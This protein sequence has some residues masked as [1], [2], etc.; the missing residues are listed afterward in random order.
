MYDRIFSFIPSNL[1][2]K[3]LQE[4]AFEILELVKQTY[5]EHQ[6]GKTHTPGSFFLRYPDKPN[7]RII[8]LPAFVEKHNAAGIKWIASHP[9]NHQIGLPRAS[10]IIVLNDYETGFPNVCM[11]GSQI[12]AMRTALSALLAV[13][14]LQCSISDLKQCGF[15]GTGLI[16]GTIYDNLMKLGARD[17]SVDLFDSQQE[18]C[19]QFME[20]HHI[21]THLGNIHETLSDLLSHCSTVF[22]T[23]TSLKPYVDTI[24][25]H[26]KPS[27]FLL[28]ISLRDLAPNIILD[29]NNV[30]DDINHVLAANTSVHLASQQCGHRDFINGTIADSINKNIQLDASKRTVF[31]PMGLGT[32]DIALAE[33]CYQ[34]AIEHDALQPAEGFF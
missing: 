27:Q 22:F 8:A 34:Y 19:T 16:A 21:P 26:K 7:A 9:D 29:A 17:V 33:Y 13:E 14:Y 30:V 12:S 15:V 32:L 6:S 10:A 2:T 28:N 20:D 18:K 24:D 11:E 5:L 1:I 25:Y 31:S 3:C 23:T 4:K